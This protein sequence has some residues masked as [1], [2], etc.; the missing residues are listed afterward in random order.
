MRRIALLLATTMGATAS[1][2]MWVG[3]GAAAVFGLA[4]VLALVLGVGTM[5][6]AVAPGGT[7]TFRL[8]QTNSID[9]M[10]TLVGNVA[11][12]MLRVDNHSTA[13]GA[14]ALDLRVEAGQAPMK[15]NSATMVGQLNADKVDGKDATDFYAAGS[16]VSDSSHAD[17]ADSATNAQNAANADKLDGIDSGALGLT[18]LQSRSKLS[19]CT[20]PGFGATCAP[21]TV[22]VPAGKAYNVTVLFTFAISTAN[23]GK[24]S[25]CSAIE[26]GP[27]PYPT[28]CIESGSSPNGFFDHIDLAAGDAESATYTAQILS[29]PAGTYTFETFINTSQQVTDDQSYQARTLV[30]ITD[31]AAP[32][33]SHL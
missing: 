22:K 33:P 9:A 29:L 8:G 15:V 27:I 16:K 19:S 31:A 3:R 18:T 13:A 1:K 23:T 6:L 25:Y 24:V 28:S 4:L 12:T 32:R 26:G 20:I 2:L 21:V 5:A 17:Q 10:S 14:T 7:L 11:G 30:M